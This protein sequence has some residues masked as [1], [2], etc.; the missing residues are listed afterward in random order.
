MKTFRIALMLLA[1]VSLSAFSQKQ[2]LINENFTQKM[3]D[4]RDAWIDAD[5]PTTLAGKESKFVGHSVKYYAKSSPA[6]PCDCSKGRV[7]IEMTRNDFLS[8]LE[9]PELPSCGVLK[10]GVQSNGKDCKRGIVLQKMDKGIWVTVDQIDLEAPP[11]GTC[12]MWEPN[13]AKSSTPVRFRLI[14]T[15]TGNV[16]VTDVYAEAY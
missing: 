12:V 10:L 11:T 7:N 15:K 8:S 13:N 9:F 14:G 3:A 2:V 4:I 16:F 1:V 6:G 5:F